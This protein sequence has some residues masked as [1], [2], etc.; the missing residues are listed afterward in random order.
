MAGGV[1]YHWEQCR[2][3][4]AQLRSIGDGRCL[5][6]SQRLHGHALFS[7]WYN[8]HFPWKQPRCFGRSSNPT[9]AGIY[10]YTP[11]SSFSLLPGTGYF[12]VLTAATSVANG[13]YDWSHAGTYSY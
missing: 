13:P 12:I 10:T 11:A 2:R 7:N 5:R 9:T 4:F 1:F 6:Q 3:L 8:R